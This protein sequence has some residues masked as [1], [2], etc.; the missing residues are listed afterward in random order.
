ME[1]LSKSVDGKDKSVRSGALQRIRNE[2]TI[3]AVLVVVGF[4]LAFGLTT[5]IMLAVVVTCMKFAIPDCITAWLV[6]R[7]DSDRWHGIAVAFLFAAMGFARASIFAFVILFAGVAVMIMLG[8]PAGAGQLLTA[9]F[10]AG[11]ICAYGFLAIVFPLAFSAAM[12]A[13]RTG[14]KLEFAAGLTKLRRS[15]S[16]AD[17]SKVNLEVWPGLKFVGIASGLSL[18]IT[19]ILPLTV[20]QGELFALIFVLGAFLS[21][22]IWMVTFWI[23]T[24]PQNKS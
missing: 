2:L 23:I 1:P 7:H 15:K 3:E 16:D 14:T 4:A 12:I 21:P 20:M 5:K 24:N 8:G 6:L 17:R 11:A 10:G 19:M 13:W 9:G 18:V 22:P